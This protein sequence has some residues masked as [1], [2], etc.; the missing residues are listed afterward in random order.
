[1]NIYYA[2]APSFA[3]SIIWNNGILTTNPRFEKFQKQ[4]EDIKVDDPMLNTIS[5]RCYEIDDSIEGAYLAGCLSYIVKEDTP[6]CPIV[7][8]QTVAMVDWMYFNPLTGETT[9]DPLMDSEGNFIT[10]PDA[11][12]EYEKVVLNPYFDMDYDYVEDVRGDVSGDGE[13]SVIDVVMLQRH[14]LNMSDLND[15]YLARADINGDN[16]VD[17]IDVVMLARILVGITV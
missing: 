10:K 3:T 11:Y 16:A 14:I 12:W 15:E 9:F 13:V 6:Q 2:F 5:D 17:L 4:T 8:L 7:D 1:K